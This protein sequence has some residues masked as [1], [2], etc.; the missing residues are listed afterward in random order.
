[1]KQLYRY[2]IIILIAGVLD[3]IWLSNMT[4]SFYKPELGNL[5]LSK[6]NAIPAILFYIIY[7]VGI[8][9]FAVNPALKLK[10]PIKALVFGALLGLV[11]YST[12]DLSNL[13]TVNGFTNTVAL[14]DILWG[15]T[16][17]GSVSVL[18]YFIVNNS[19]K[20]KRKS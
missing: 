7:A 9:V 20:S 3:A 4:S 18:T 15:M 17:T 11:A 10:S 12:Y 1:M 2:F 19:S 14:V 8:L 16:L 6:P 13:A 5:L